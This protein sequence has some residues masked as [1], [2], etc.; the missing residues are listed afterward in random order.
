MYNQVEYSRWTLTVP[1][2]NAPMTTATGPS[3]GTM[4]L[5][6]TASPALNDVANLGHPGGRWSDTGFLISLNKRCGLSAARTLS[7]CRSWTA[8]GK[9][10]KNKVNTQVDDNNTCKGQS[11][12]RVLV[13]DEEAKNSPTRS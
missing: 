12:A 10:N 7:L 8:R 3:L 5:G 9:Q 2:A 4:V 11:T 13:H 1:C 6:H